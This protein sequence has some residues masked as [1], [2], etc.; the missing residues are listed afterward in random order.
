MPV[1]ESDPSSPDVE[2]SRAL[3]T[4]Y[5]LVREVGRGGASLVFL[6]QDHKHDR[7]VA[8]KVLRPELAAS[9]GAERFLREIGTAARLQHPHIVPIYDSG[10]AD[11]LL[12]LVMPFV[13]GESLRERLEREHQLTLADALRLTLEVA[14]A[15]SF[16]HSRNIVHRDVKPENILLFR[17]HA[18]VADFGIA[19]RLGRAEDIGESALTDGMFTGTPLYMAPEQMFPDTPVDERA[20]LYSLASVLYE[21]LEGRPPY[22]GPTSIAILSRK[23]VR[24]APPPRHTLEPLPVHVQSALLKA[25]EREREQRFASV[26][27]FAEALTATPAAPFTARRSGATTVTSIAVLPFANRSGIDSDDYLSDGISEDL[28][29]A[30]STLPGLRVIG[31]TSAFGFKGRSDDA[32]AIG[33]ELG[34]H[35]V[36]GGGVRRAGERLRITAELTEVA[37]GFALWSERFDRDVS[38]LFAVQDEISRAIA[39]ALRVKL[40][41]ETVR[42]V[43]TPTANF[44]A[45][46]SYLKGRFEWSQR[47]AYSMQR[48][49]EHMQEAVETDPTFTLA[50][51]GLADCYLTLAVYDVLAP[52]QA[53]PKALAAA[54]QALQYHSRSPEGLTARASARALYEFDWPGAET[55]YVAALGERE[56]SPVTHQWYAMHL[57]APRRRFLEARA[58][59]ARAREL[60][61]LSPAI[62]A[63]GGILRLY[64]GDPEQAIR[65]LELVITQHPS[66]GLAH[67]FEGLA[68]SALERHADAVRTLERAVL[69]T[70]RSIESQSALAY[71]LARDG[72]VEAARAI[73]DSLHHTAAT[74]YVSAISL[75]QVHVA[76]DEPELALNHLERAQADRAAGLTFLSVRPSFAPLRNTPRF[77]RI[78]ESLER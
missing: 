19:K 3:G 9:L 76:L 61:P 14:E 78:L 43:E 40:R 65:E 57:L 25:L 77:A 74:Q 68:H 66:F 59:T 8:V 51:T 11:S 72:R 42:L 52:A 6:A 36:L 10:D 23:T 30:L 22:D 69:L 49:L 15:L 71:A 31:R 26:A 34:V 75:A 1:P 48:S 28:I 73:L 4:R 20:D 24:A 33:A 12:Y 38:D 16:A 60:D 64:E 2:L 45:Y 39:D 21:L 46:E 55:D 56:Q 35:A 62:A 54:T 29:H 13:E 41:P 70:G 47:T 44:E 32:R 7:Q 5:S 67:L 18:L 50:W 17:G 58:H 53:M 37:G 27:E 63:S